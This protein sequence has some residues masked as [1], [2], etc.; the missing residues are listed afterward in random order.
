MEDF[1]DFT[2]SPSTA[3]RHQQSTDKSKLESVKSS[4][5]QQIFGISP[6]LSRKQVISIEE[7]E[8]SSTA[9]SLN[10][11]WTFWLDK[12][13]PNLSAVEY[14]ASLKEIF[15]VSTVESFWSVVNHLPKPSKLKPRYGYHFMRN[16]ARPLWEDEIH[17]KGGMWK[18]RC[19]KHNTDEVWQEILLACIGEQFQLNLN[20]DD[21]VLGVSVNI[22]K[23]DDLIQVW[24]KSS[25]NVDNSQIVNKIKSLLPGVEFE[26]NFYKAHRTHRVYEPNFR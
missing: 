7:S 10:T 17:A 24:N 18:L 22:R 11:G 21:E 12:S 13:I 5:Q 26:T 16:K 15:T 2:M 19:R 25:S 20:Q 1:F 4:E 23:N 8:K 9:N 6:K 14:E 3:K